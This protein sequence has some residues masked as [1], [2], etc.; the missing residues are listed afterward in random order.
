MSLVR[1]RAAGTTRGKFQKDSASLGPA[2]DGFT[3][4]PP[5]KL[6]LGLSAAALE[7]FL[8]LLS[9]AVSS[10]FGQSLSRRLW[11]DEGCGSLSTGNF[12]MS[13]IQV[14]CFA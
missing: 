10:V 1:D 9:S 8:R 6:T 3:P 7:L 12:D 13:Y 11:P 5:G 14:F 2:S 4:T